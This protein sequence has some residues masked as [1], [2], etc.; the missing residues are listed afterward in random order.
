MTTAA[1]QHLP[2]AGYDV[3]LSSVRG[4]TIPFDP[5][6]MDPTDPDHKIV[7]RF[8]EDGADRDRCPLRPGYITALPLRT[9]CA[10]AQ[11]LVSLG[12]LSVSN[13]PTGLTSDRRANDAR[14]TADRIK[15]FAKD[16]PTY[17]CR[18]RDRR[19]GGDGHPQ[20]R[21]HRLPAGDRL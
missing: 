7:H 3:T 16:T 13:R 21:E 8:F 11:L 10:P 20:H 9:A 14:C 5:A 18:L 6:S 19:G 17:T 12:N 1:Q 15:A 2:R 4:G